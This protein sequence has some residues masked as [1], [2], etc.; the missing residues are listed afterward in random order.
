M[1]IKVQWN[2]ATR[3]SYGRIFRGIPKMLVLFYF[4]RKLMV[5][6]KKIYRAFRTRTTLETKPVREIFHFHHLPKLYIGFNML[7]IVFWRKKKKKSLV[8]FVIKCRHCIISFIGFHWWNV[9]QF[10]NHIHIIIDSSH[11]YEDE[12]VPQWPNFAPSCWQCVGVCHSE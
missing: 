4:L 11:D 5:S 9:H 7:L 1:L 8:P 12:V 10:Q 3:G 2:M 6:D